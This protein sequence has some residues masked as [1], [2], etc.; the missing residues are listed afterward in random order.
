M[1]T[2]NIQIPPETEQTLRDRASRFGKPFEVFLQEVIDRAVKYEAMMTPPPPP[3][4][5]EQRAAEWR[6]WVARQ[7]VRPVIAD[8]TRE[9]IYE[10][11]GE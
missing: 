1:F 2:V 11:R 10:G 9:S 4:S 3:M 5:P 7:P 6:A 8:D